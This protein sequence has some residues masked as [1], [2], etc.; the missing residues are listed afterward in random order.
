MSSSGDK[1]DKYQKYL[2]K[3]HAGFNTDPDLINNIVNKATGSNMSEDNRIVEGEVNEVHGITTNS[4]QEI[5]VR[6]SRS[7]HSRFEVEKWAI[8]RAR[9]AGVLA[10]EILLL[11]QHDSEDENLTF[12]VQKKIEGERLKALMSRVGVESEEVIQA[13]INAGVN[14]AKIHSVKTD[15]YG[16]LRE[17]GKGKFDTWEKFMLEWVGKREY[18]IDS[19]NELG[20][21]EEVIDKALGILEANSN[22]Y[23]NVEPHLLHGDYGGDHIFVQDGKVTGIIDFENC[24]GGDVAWDFGWWSYFWKSRPPIELLIEGYKKEG[25]L[26]S[27]F[28]L[29]VNLCKLRLGL[30]MIWYY[31]QEQNEAGQNL[32]KQRL[33]DIL[34]DF[35]K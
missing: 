22:I 17:P 29:R 13:T 15:G 28:E 10:P 18:L 26:G 21:E 14:L 27:Q 2:E 25:D 12:C 1:E 19:A 9:D 4:G 34:E 8:E 20:L 35:D 16:G 32:A 3:K 11:E 24:M 7:K 5:I 6:I 33:I 31:T 23:Q 30:D